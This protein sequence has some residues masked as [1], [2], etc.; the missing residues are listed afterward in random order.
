MYFQS[1]KTLLKL[2]EVKFIAKLIEFD[3]RIRIIIEIDI[4]IIE[5][6]FHILCVEISLGLM[7]IHNQSTKINLI[8]IIITL[9]GT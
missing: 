9:L 8:G 2:V 5:K 3:T 6:Q 4:S 1:N 7:N